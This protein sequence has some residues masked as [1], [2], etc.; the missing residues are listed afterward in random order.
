METTNTEPS[1]FKKNLPLIIAM[2]IP[3]LMIVLVTAFIYLPGI[4]KKPKH[5]FL[6]ASGFGIDYYGYNTRYYVSGGRLQESI[7]PTPTPYPGQIIEDKPRVY[8]DFYIYDV[9]TEQSNKIS[10][11]QAM[12]LNLDPSQISEDGYKV[13]RGNYSG[14]DI[15][16]GG[17]GSDYNSWFLKGHNRSKK[18]QL[19][20]TSTYYYDF[21]FLG[22]I[23]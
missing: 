10:L 8:P 4:G 13:E 17:G 20:V 12:A 16:F 19:K 2:C 3:V 23:N 7:Q 18:L 1:R 9:V 5:N 21:Q 11:E 15:F 6:Y 14:G 22:W